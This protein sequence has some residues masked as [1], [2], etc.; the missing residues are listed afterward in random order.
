MG[1]GGK[2]LA[3]LL[4]RSQLRSLQQPHLPDQIQGSGHGHHLRTQPEVFCF[5][6]SAP[7]LQKNEGG[8]PGPLAATEAGTVVEAW[9]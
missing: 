9:L 4:P 1:G 8:V 3:G 2:G 6:S 7:G 5:L